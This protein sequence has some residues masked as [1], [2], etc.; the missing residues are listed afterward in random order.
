M[1]ALNRITHLITAGLLMLSASAW[2]QNCRYDVGSAPRI[3]VANLNGSITVGRDVPLGTEVFITSYYPGPESTIVCSRGDV[4]RTR[5][6]VSLPFP[7][8]SYV[9]PRFGDNVYDTNVPGIGV[10]VWWNG[11]AFPYTVQQRFDSDDTFLLGPMQVFDVSFIK[12]GPVGAGTITGA[13]LPTIEYRMDGVNSGVLLWSGRI[14]GSLNIVSRTCTTSDLAVDLGTH[15][16]SEIPNVGTTTQWVNVPVQLSNCP[17]FFG[18]HREWR[19]TGTV[20]ESRGRT[21]NRIRYRVDPV[22]RV[23]DA[24]R[25]VMALQDD[26]VTV[27]ASG[28][29]IQIGSGISDSVGYGVLQ[30]SGLILTE[31][32]NASYIIPLRARYIRQAA[33]ARAGQAN[34]AATIT[35]EYN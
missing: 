14:Q 7:K 4:S 31:T 11:H 32:D 16:L 30:D 15:Q 5:R 20:Q 1:K 33:A 21:D 26:G 28:I 3:N 34:G 10:V 35:L 13:S 19:T 2:A 23:L 24:A 17:A 8:S 27:S 25:S 18:Q 22:T 29:G 6:Y 12:T 9:S